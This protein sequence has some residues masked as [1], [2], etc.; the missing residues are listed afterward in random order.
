MK[1]PFC[2]KEYKYKAAL[3]KHLVRHFTGKE[4]DE[5][6]R[7]LC[8]VEVRDVGDDRLQVLIDRFEKLDARVGFVEQ[9]LAYIRKVLENILNVLGGRLP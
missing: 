5:L 7:R 4:G 9:D 1:C 6:L 2:P 8:N 3:V